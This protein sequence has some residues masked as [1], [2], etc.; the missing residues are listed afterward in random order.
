M[1]MPCKRSATRWRASVCEVLQSNSTHTIE[2]PGAEPERT[3][4]T[5]A[6]PLTAVSIG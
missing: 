5:P 3:R 1:A 2:I 6:A 4:R